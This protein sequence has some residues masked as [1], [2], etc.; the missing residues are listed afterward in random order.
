VTVVGPGVTP[1]VEWE[2]DGVG[3]YNREADAR[4]NAIFDALMAGDGRCAPER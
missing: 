4:A 2:G 3:R 1:D